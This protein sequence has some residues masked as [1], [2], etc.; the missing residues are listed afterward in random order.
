MRRC[1]I[2]ANGGLGGVR[3]ASRQVSIKALHVPGIDR[4]RK[5]D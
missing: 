1:L 2:V 4:R 5:A 3:M